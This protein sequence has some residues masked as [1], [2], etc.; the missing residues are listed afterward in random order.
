VS[1]LP[2]AEVVRKDLERD[3]VGRRVAAVTVQSPVLVARG[4]NPDLAGALTGRRITAVDRRGVH[5][6]LDLEG[7]QSLVVRSGEHGT[8]TVGPVEEGAGRHLQLVA[9]LDKG[10]ALRYVD[11]GE[12][13]E[14][15]VVPTAEVAALPELSKGGIDPLA[16]TFTWTAFGKE[17][18]RRDLALKTL[19]ADP[20]FVVGLGDRYS[21]EV[22][23]GAGLAGRRSS[24]KLS[25]Q[26]VRRLYRSLLEV[27]QDAVKH[28]AAAE[29]EASE[30]AED[31]DDADPE[32]VGWLKV[33][34]REGLPC[35]RCRQRI[36]YGE[37]VEG[38]HSYHCANCQT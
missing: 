28:R 15:L 21:D 24:S 12:D 22:L 7:G 6:V 33:W 8:L 5:L 10:G 1:L 37:V 23:W 20:S 34:N 27:L 35:A 11:S 25:A 18:V 31:A 29:T 17:M 16:E 30:D 9:T 3:A 26:E 38:Q 14:F 4:G 19:L 2:E 36:R 32:P 13:G